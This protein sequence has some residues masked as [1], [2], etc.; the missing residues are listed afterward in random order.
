MTYMLDQCSLTVESTVALNL[1]DHK[2]THK[3]SDDCTM[4]KYYGI[5]N[6]IPSSA[7]LHG[8]SFSFIYVSV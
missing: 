4:L 7:A 8:N 2:L 3:V 1:Y 5:Q 6:V